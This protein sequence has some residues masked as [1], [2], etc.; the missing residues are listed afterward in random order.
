MSK[1]EFD[2]AGPDDQELHDRRRRRLGY[3]DADDVT[4][5]ES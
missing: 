2:G 3:G 4:G 5:D 1:S